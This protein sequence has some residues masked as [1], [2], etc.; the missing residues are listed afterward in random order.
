MLPHLT[1]RDRNINATKALLLGLHSE[2]VHN[3]LTVTGDPVPNAE[4]SE[5]NAVY[6][7][8]SRKLASYITSLNR[9][10]FN[11]DMKIFTALNI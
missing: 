3:V 2:G 9:D 1:C 10:I 11:N 7:F 4:R 5:V 8:N 6:Q